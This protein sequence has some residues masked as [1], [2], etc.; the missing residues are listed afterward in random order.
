M[1]C[2]VSYVN[3]DDIMWFMKYTVQIII[4]KCQQGI[5]TL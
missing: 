4:V 3:I 2:D 1:S 5:Y